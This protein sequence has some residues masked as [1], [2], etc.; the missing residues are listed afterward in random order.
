MFI[1][2]YISIWI[3][4][5]CILFH[6]KILGIRL[7]N[8]AELR[9]RLE[10]LVRKQFGVG[11]WL[12]VCAY[13]RESDDFRWNEQAAWVAC[14]QLGYHGGMARFFNSFS[15]S[16]GYRVNDIRCGNGKILCK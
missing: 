15:V 13:G 9:G 1:V 7:E 6:T 11:Q 8:D 4:Q 16:N 2:L 5:V 3:Q 12:A 10:L 14:R